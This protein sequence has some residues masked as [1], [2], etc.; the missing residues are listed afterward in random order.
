M[1]PIIDASNLLLDAVER[2]KI[3]L[4]LLV[5]D[6]GL[7]V[8]PEF[9]KRLVRD[10]GSVAVFP[11]V[12]RARIGQG[13]RRGQIVDGV[14]LDDNSYANVAIKRAAGLGASAKGF[15]TCH[16]WPRKCYDERYHTA[17]ANIVLLPRAL[18]GLSDHDIEIQKAL[19]Y[20]AFELYD[21]YPEEMSQPVKPR[22]Y[23]SEWREPQPDP[24]EN[25]RSPRTVSALSKSASD[26]TTQ[27]KRRELPDLID[28]WSHKPDLNVHKIIA[29]VVQSRG[30]ISRDEL[31][32]K[33]ANVTQSRNPS[34]A[35]ASLLTNSGNA[36]GRIFADNDGIICFH[37]EVEALVRSHEWNAR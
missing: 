33:I 28:R 14:R 34:G 37:P 35:V 25:V 21:W 26:K 1:R 7:W 29:L 9:H 30:G 2:H 18:A 4:S 3:H 32:K 27:E 31:V 24:E 13:E 12:R 16:I 10:T 36:Y 20:R 17:I 11:K 8:N 15:E 5:A 23:P 19:Q 22:F 6:T